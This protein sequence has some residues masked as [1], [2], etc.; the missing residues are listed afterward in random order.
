MK[1]EQIR[2]DAALADVSREQIARERREDEAARVR[3]DDKYSRMDYMKLRNQGYPEGTV[4]IIGQNLFRNGNYKLHFYRAVIG[5]HKAVSGI[6]AHFV[7]QQTEEW[8]D[9]PPWANVVGHE[10]EPRDIGFYY[11]HLYWLT[12]EVVEPIVLWWM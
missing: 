11:D 10:G 6:I 12:G 1:S 8:P 5:Y 3:M 9:V 2:M 4:V 7:E